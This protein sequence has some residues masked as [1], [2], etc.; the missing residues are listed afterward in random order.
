MRAAGGREDALHAF[1]RAGVREVYAQLAG[2]DLPAAARA[3]ARRRLA[4]F[5]DPGEPGSA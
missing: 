2:L 1:L 3:E 4:R 5:D